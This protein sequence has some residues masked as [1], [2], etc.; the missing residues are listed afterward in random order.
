MG[1]SPRRGGWSGS[2]GPSPCART[3]R[4]RPRTRLQRRSGLGSGSWPW[5]LDV[6]REAAVLVARGPDPSTV[7]LDDRAADRQAHAEP[8]GLAGDEAVEDAFQLRLLDPSPRVLDGD[9]DRKSVV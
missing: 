4:R 3:R 6:H 8:A 5:D 2:G 7:R 9:L 1:T